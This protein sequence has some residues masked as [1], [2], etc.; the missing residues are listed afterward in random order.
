MTNIQVGPSTPPRNTKIFVEDSNADYSMPSSPSTA[1][2][3]QKESAHEMQEMQGPHLH[4]LVRRRPF[5]FELAS[6]VAPLRLWRM[7]C[8]CC[9]VGVASLLASCQEVEE[10]RISSPES[11]SFR[12][13]EVRDS[14]PQMIMMEGASGKKKLLRIM[15]EESQSKL[16]I[17]DC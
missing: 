11:S 8:T 12:G 5:A 14:G 15:M 3:K 9:R 7:I 1:N 16:K 10:V 4:I 13:G 6:I 17:F 2:S